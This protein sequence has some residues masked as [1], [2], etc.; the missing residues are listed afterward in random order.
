MYTFTTLSKI[1]RDI[2]FISVSRT[3]NT[4]HESNISLIDIIC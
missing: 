2:I 3:I 1:I 4:E